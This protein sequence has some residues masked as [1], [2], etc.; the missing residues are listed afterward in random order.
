MIIEPIN[1]ADKTKLFLLLDK[2]TKSFSGRN[3]AFVITTNSAYLGTIVILVTGKRGTVQKVLNFVYN[4]A[5]GDWEVYSDNHV[6]KL[7]DI[8]EASSI[9]KNKITK[10]QTILTKI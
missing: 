4:Q 6:Y 1:Q 10:L 9:V 7:L 8:S 3:V 5:T 2:L